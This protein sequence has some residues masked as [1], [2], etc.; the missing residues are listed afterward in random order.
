MCVRARARVCVCVAFVGCLLLIETLS[1]SLAHH[2]FFFGFRLLAAAWPVLCKDAAERC[3]GVSRGIQGC[4]LSHHPALR[5][6]V[7]VARDK[8]GRRGKGGDKKG[9]VKREGALG[10]R[11]E[12]NFEREPDTQTYRHTDT[13][14]HTDTHRRTQTHIDAHRHTQTHTDTHGHTQTYISTSPQSLV[15]CRA[16]RLRPAARAA[17]SRVFRI[18][19]QN[20]DGV[21]LLLLLLE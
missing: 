10:R 4:H 16:H 18:C 19:D 14:T 1:C 6:E 2:F 15:V 7:G 20:K 5:R 8:Q 17:L 21:L 11:R 3:G 13:Q 12:R 9:W